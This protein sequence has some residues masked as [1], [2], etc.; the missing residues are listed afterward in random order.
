MPFF[1][2][3]TSKGAP[4]R[5]RSGRRTAGLATI[6]WVRMLLMVHMLPNETYDRI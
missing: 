5:A 1:P 6:M 3:A 4:M 2:G